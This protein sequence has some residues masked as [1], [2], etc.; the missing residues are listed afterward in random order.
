[1]LS[2]IVPAAIASA[3]IAA[4]L[5]VA[6]AVLTAAWMTSHGFRRPDPPPP[7]DPA[8][9]IQRGRPLAAQYD[10]APIPA[11]VVRP[12]E[13]D[14][15]RDCVEVSALRRLIEE[16][17]ANAFTNK[18]WQGYVVGRLEHIRVSSGIA[19]VVL[20]DRAGGLQR[21]RTDVNAAAF[22]HVLKTFRKGD[23][24]LIAASGAHPDPANQDA[25]Y[26]VTVDIRNP[27]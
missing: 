3:L 18:G 12:P 22:Q 21:V 11:A 26:V 2:R 4:L 10:P 17:S 9:L 8:P 13:L 16:R 6:T 20:S 1:M 25:M 7:A 24:V 19:E 23:V 14:L 27:S 5:V 15:P